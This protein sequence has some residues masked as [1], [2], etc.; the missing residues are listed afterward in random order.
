VPV[1]MHGQHELCHDRLDE[2]AVRA[3]LSG[4]PLESRA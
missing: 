3:Y 2:A 4:F 1:L